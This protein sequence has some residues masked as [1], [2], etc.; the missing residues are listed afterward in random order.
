MILALVNSGTSFFAGFVIF[1]FLGFM[2]HEQ[3]VPI[4]KVA[5]SG[6]GLAYIAYPRGVAMMPLAPLWSCLFFLMIILVGLD[7]QVIMALYSLV[8]L[9]LQ[10]CDNCRVL[11]QFVWSMEQ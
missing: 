1:T 2:A 4:D 8:S 9:Q 11:S 10:S 5:E 7:S 3:N 6:P